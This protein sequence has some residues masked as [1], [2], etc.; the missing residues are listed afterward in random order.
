MT[1]YN[2]P[3]T[4]PRTG[5]D[6]MEIELVFNLRSC[7]TC[8]F[9][10]PADTSKQP[11][12]PYPAYDFE[13]NTPA[14]NT[15]TN[16][17]AEYTWLPKG[18]T[19]DEI[20]PN[21]E[22]MDGCRKV[23]IMT[24]GI[25]P[26]LTAFEANAQGTRWVYPNFTSNNGT[27]AATKFAYYYRYRS[28]YQES[29]DQDVMNKY[30]LPDGAIKAQ[31]SGIMKSALR[32]SDSPAFDIEVLYDGD[33]SGTKISVQ[34]VTGQPRYVVPVN[35]GDKFNAG[36][37][38]AAKLRVPAGVELPVNQGWLGYYMQFVPAL[39]LFEQFLQSQGYS[40]ANLQ[41]GEDVGQLDMVACASPRWTPEFLGGTET[42]VNQVVSNCVSKNAW[43]L[44]QLVH[45]KPAV[46]FLVGESSYD[47]FSKAFSKSL[48]RDTPLSA[49]PQDG[50]FT[51]FN[52]TIDPSNPLIFEFTGN[53]DG[54]PYNISTRVI[55]TPHFSYDYNFI[56][57]FRMSETDWTRFQ[58]SNKA[59]VEF[60]KGDPGFEVLAPMAGETFMSIHVNSDV[61]GALS[62]LETKYAGAYAV[63]KPLFYNPHADM[64]NVMQTLF[65]QGKMTYVKGQNGKK[66]Y[67]ARTDGSCQF[68][69]N[70]YWTFPQGCP[71][72]KTTVTPPTP[73]FLDQV[74]AA[75]AKLG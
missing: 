75:I 14:L 13:S 32:N 7:G 8:S 50:A 10:W 65:A 34:G 48:K 21:G 68:C 71:Y 1:N 37:I 11:Y 9:F 38:L 35:E 46:L 59:C 63:L 40:D 64:A 15:Q 26:N 72:D 23:P 5:I 53:I 17:V 74:A 20:F 56:P 57:Q 28:V 43:A 60:I 25:N 36:D 66:G 6:P 44:K 31:K 27:D 41:I 18:I 3:R 12:G 52:Q 4:A 67:L 42:G 51:L 49:Q 19:T 22:V 62:A 73:G 69:V 55:V 16:P 54:Q 70:K 30:L 61:T 58:S 29:F 24:I 33:S 39:N 47:M 2:P 45:T